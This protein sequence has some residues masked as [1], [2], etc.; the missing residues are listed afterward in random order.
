LVAAG[1]GEAV[2]IEVPFIEELFIEP[3]ALEHFMNLPLASRHFVGA[4]DAMAL[5]HFMNLPFASRHDLAEAA[6]PMPTANERASKAVRKRVIRG[7]SFRM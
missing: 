6:L 1:A 3:I 7:V 2:C 4:G 5:G